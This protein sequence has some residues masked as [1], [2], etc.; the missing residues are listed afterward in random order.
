MTPKTTQ[1][2]VLDTP[3]MRK[4]EKQ[5]CRELVKSAM[6]EM[7]VDEAIRI[8]DYI[9]FTG[10]ICVSVGWDYGQ[11]KYIYKMRTPKEHLQAMDSGYPIRKIQCIFSGGRPD[12][13]RK[14]YAG[15]IA[16]LLTDRIMCMVDTDGFVSLI[17]L[18][19]NCALGMA[20]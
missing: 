2:M 4:S 5:E 11:N 6:S 14:P 7:F 16:D 9:G 18:D 10:K 19:T 15:T 1:L 12:L 20:Q 8:L 13:P 3:T 17:E